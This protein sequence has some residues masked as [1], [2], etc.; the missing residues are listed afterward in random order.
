MLEQCDPFVFASNPAKFADRKTTVKTGK[1]LRV[2][3]LF[4]L[5]RE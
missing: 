1:L 5:H 3:R 2:F 4:N